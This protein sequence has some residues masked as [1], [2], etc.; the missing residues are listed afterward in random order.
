[1]EARQ[2]LVDTKPGGERGDGD[3]PPFADCDYLAWFPETR[4]DESAQR[5][6]AT[7]SDES[8]PPR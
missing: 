1:M 2:T 6:Q 8:G 5:P 3:E 4:K 7:L